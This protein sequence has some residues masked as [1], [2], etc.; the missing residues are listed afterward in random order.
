[1]LLM[2]LMIYLSFYKFSQIDFANRLK[3]RISIATRLYIAGEQSGAERLK[4]R[5]K[6]QEKLPGE[7]IGIYNEK[8]EAVLI[9]GS[10]PHWPDK[11]ISKV[12]RNGSIEYSDNGRYV[13]GVQYKNADDDFVVLAMARDPE[14][15]RRSEQFGL[16]MAVAFLLSILLLFM[17]GR[18]FAAKSLSPIGKLVGQMQNISAHS[19]DTRIAIRQED[20]EIGFLAKNFN[21]LLGQLE[22]A[23]ELQRAFVAN[24]SHELRTPIT[25]IIGETEV[26]LN[27]DRQPEEYRAVMQ[28]ILSESV[29]LND[30]ISG[31]IDLA[32]VDY[33][34]IR[35]TLVPIRIDDLVWELRDYW[36]K[37]LYPNALLVVMDD[38]PANESSLIIRAN[39]ALLTIALN[40]IIG[41]AFK[42]SGNKPVTCTLEAQENY[43]RVRI[44]DSGIGMS[45][46]EQARIFEAFYRS[47]RSAAYSGSG[48]GLYVTQKIA[49]LFNAEIN[50]ASVLNNGT[51][52]T[53]QFRMFEEVR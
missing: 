30:T 8:N 31:L 39:R 41:N 12:R 20:D 48:I 49:A 2:M 37:R 16:V 14:R 29:R 5:I 42:F 6:F 38:I 35:A 52:V 3:S 51:V 11:I 36:G 10:K 47:Q 7:V 32:Q 44:A 25:S 50:V 18:W 21:Q 9:P 19:L 23:F 1:M 4:M 22:K 53:V 24:A 43:L 27:Q 26:A 33:N 13:V 28:S 17:A 46:G 45:A 40:N 34:S 15:I